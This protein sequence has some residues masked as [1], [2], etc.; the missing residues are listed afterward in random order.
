VQA[1]RAVE[2]YNSLGIDDPALAPS[3]NKRLP[4]SE[5]ASQQRLKRA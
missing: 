1:E 2:F 5:M 3:K 4:E